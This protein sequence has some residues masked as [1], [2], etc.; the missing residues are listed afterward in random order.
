[1]VLDG[2]ITSGARSGEQI[3]R[4]LVKNSPVFSKFGPHSKIHFEKSTRLNGRVAGKTGEFRFA[5]LT[6]NG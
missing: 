2:V 5:H 6:V 4:G 3:V 1:M